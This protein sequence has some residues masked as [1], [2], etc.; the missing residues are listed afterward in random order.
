MITD[1]KSLALRWASGLTKAYP[2]PFLSR[3]YSGIKGINKIELKRY[4]RVYVRVHNTGS[5]GAGQGMALYE[6]KTER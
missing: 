6:T 3:P 5:R 1:E 2:L 4:V